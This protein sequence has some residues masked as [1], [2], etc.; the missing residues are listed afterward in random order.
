LYE[1]A[2]DLTD[3]SK[4]FFLVSN[5]PNF[6][7]SNQLAGYTNA[8]IDITDLKNIEL[9]L[10]NKNNE[11][12]KINSELDNF[13]Y[14]VSHDL[15]S[16]LLSIKGLIMLTKMHPKLDSE[17]MEYLNMAES[18]V[19]RLDGT[20]QEILEY[21][22]NARLEIT[23]EPVQL[24]EMA[25]QIFED[26]KYAAEDH[27]D[28]KLDCEGDSLIISDKTRINTLLKNIIG[29]AVKYRS[30]QREA[31]IEFSMKRINNK[32]A[33]S[34]KDNGEGIPADSLEKIFNMFYRASK[35]SEGTGLGLYICKE[36]V[37]KLNGSITV[38]SQLGVGTTVNIL[39]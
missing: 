23:M 25:S 36:I 8:F 5:A 27:I 35:T 32:V 4:R 11:L 10:L 3:K 39:I 2:I 15:R 16:P 6:N 12:K 21:S 9:V 37:T 18:S 19:N 22:R 1:I 29:N 38:D 7:G 31:V 28:F 33:I 30:Q 34:I 26:L 14:S 17:I 13:V 20:I 24:C